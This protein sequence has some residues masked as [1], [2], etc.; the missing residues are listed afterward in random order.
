M[1]E[2]EIRLTNLLISLDQQHLFDDWEDPGVNDD[3]KHEFFV[4]I[5]RLHSSYPSPGGIS[6]YVNNARKLLASAK[7]GANPLEGFTPSVPTGE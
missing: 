5:D 4:Q 7:K 6:D 3:L 2:R 1:T